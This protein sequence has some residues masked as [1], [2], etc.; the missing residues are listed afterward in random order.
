MLRKRT[1]VVSIAHAAEYLEVTYPTIRKWIRKGILDAEETPIGLLVTV[2]SVQKVKG[3]KDKDGNLL[4]IGKKGR[5]RK[6]KIN[7]QPKE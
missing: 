7:I 1:D 2:Q 5:P 6:A 4:A 3:A